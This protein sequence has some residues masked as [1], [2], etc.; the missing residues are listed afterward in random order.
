MFASLVSQPRE[1]SLTYTHRTQV[2]RIFGTL[3]NMK[4]QGFG[5]EIKPLADLMTQATMDLYGIITTELLPTPAKSHY[6]YNMRDLSKVFQGVL[7]A[8]RQFV[9]SKDA[10]TRLWVHECFRV[11]HDR[12]IDDSDR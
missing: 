6:I 2:K 4:L 12:L 9:D 1:L 7:R 10:M 11:F 3:V 5:D 8:D